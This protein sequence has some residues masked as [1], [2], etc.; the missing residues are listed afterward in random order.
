[1]DIDGTLFDSNQQISANTI[2]LIQKLQQEG[3]LFYVATGRMYQSAY[4]TAQRV[5]PET[6]VLASNGGIFNLEQNVTEHLFAPETALAIFKVAKSQRLPLFFFSKDAVYYSEFLPDYFIDK[7]DQ[8]RVNS[9]AKQNFHEIST[10]VELMKHIGQFINGIIISEDNRDGLATANLEFAT[11]PNLHV[12][13]SF[14]NNIE[15]MP[16]HVNKATAIK[17]I[18]DYYGI[19]TSEVIAFGDGENDREMLVAAGTGVAM[20]N[21]TLAIKEIATTITASNNEEGIY[22]FLKHYFRNGA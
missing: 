11:I 20:D 3:H 8:G 19:S 1:M 2:K 21:A 5:S 7:G 18:Q 15:L 13:S 10:E 6:A 14:S 22:Q 12:S 16:D 17:E 9:G 4:E